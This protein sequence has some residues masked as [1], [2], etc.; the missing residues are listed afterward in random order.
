MNKQLYSFVLHWDLQI[1][2]MALTAPFCV[3]LGSPT[4]LPS[5]L[6]AILLALSERQSLYL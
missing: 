5:F 3:T 2:Q 4:V 6:P 1:L